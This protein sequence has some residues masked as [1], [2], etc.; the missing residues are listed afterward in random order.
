MSIGERISN[1]NSKNRF[2]VNI[3]LLRICWENYQFFD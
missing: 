1:T 3:Y 2:W